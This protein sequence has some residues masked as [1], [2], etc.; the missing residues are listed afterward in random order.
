MPWE[1]PIFIEIIMV[2]FGKCCVCFKI[3]KNDNIL[4]AEWDSIDKHAGKRK[5]LDAMWFMDP[6]CG[7]MKYEIVYV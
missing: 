6:K 5:A 3:L 2:T 4:V 7:Q 1:K